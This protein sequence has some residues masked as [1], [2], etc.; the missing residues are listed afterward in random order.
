MVEDGFLPGDGLVALVDLLGQVLCCALKRQVRL[1]VLLLGLKHL[2]FKLVYPDIG[3]F[4]FHVF[5]LNHLQ[6]LLVVQVQV[7]PLKLLVL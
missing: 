3:L 4:F 6:N 5:L 1:L 2:L 7:A